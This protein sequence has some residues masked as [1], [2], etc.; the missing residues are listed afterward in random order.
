MKNLLFFL[1][2]MFFPLVED[3]ACW[4]HWKTIGKPCPEDQ[5]GWDTS[6]ATFVFYIIVG[7][8]LYEK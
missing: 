8:L 6:A 5:Y 7:F 3:I 1:W 2:M 4:V